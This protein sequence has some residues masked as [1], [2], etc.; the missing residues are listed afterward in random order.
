[1]YQLLLGRR[2]EKDLRGLP[3]TTFQ[4][5]LPQIESLATEPRPPGCRKLSGSDSDFRIRIGN[6]RVLYEIDDAERTVRI[7]RVRHRSHAYRP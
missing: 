7:L 4:R 2:A 3:A 1:M 5:V 6:Y